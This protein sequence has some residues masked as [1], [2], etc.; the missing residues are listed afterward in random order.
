MDEDEATV[1]KENWKEWEVEANALR[2]K[3]AAERAAKTA[4]QPA[5]GSG[6][7]LKPP[8]WAKP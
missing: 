4:S 6:T 8:P 5:S 3:Q 1:H 2:A 7:G